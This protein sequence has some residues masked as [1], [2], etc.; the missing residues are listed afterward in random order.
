MTAW[1]SIAIIGLSGRFPDAPNLKAFWRNLEQGVESLS[2]LSDEDLLESGVPADLFR[3]PNYVKKGTLLERADLFDAGFFG[4]NPREAEIIDPQQRIFLECAWEALEDAGYAGEPGANIIG[5]YA[6]STTSSYAFS[7]LLRNPSVLEAAGRYQVMI[8]ND[9]DYLATRVSYKL[10][11]SGPS[12][13]IQTACSTS[14][15]AVQTACNAIL[16]GQCDIALA[17]GVSVGFP[18]KSGYLYS[19]GMIFSPDGH[20]RPFDAEGRGIR[21][22]FGAGIVVLKHLDKALRDRDCIR[23]VIRGAAINN[24]GGVKMGYTTP[25]V[26]GQ[27]RAISEALRLAQVDPDSI[28]YVEAHGTAT[29]V[30]DPIEIAALSRIFRASTDRKQY[31]AIGSVKGNIGHLDAAAGV[32]GLIKTVL[33]LEHRRIPPSLNFHEPNP[34]IDFGNSPFFVNASSAE[35]KSGSEPRR[36]GVSSFGI[37]GTNAHVVLEEAPPRQESKTNWPAQLLV[38]SGKSA[39]TLQAET[40]NMAEYLAANPAVSLADACYTAQVGRRRFPY[41]RILVCSDREDA[42]RILSNSDGRRII[43]KFEEADFRPVVFM[44]SGQG[45]QHAG[46]ARGLYDSQP[47][48]RSTLDDCAAF[49]QDEIHC[50][51][52]K[53]LYSAEARSSLLTETR[54]AQPALFAIEYSLAR[55]WTSWGVQPE[56]MIGHSIGEYVAACLAGVF[57]LEDGLRLVAARGRLMQEMPAGGMMAVRLSSDELRGCI[58]GNLE[59]SLA[60]VNAPGMCTVSGRLEAI[61]EFRASLELR[62]VDCRPLH[63]SHAFHSSMMDDVLPRFHEH[64][65][66]CRLS[67]PKIPF[68]SN[69]T[70][71]WILPEEATD[72]AYWTSHLRQTVRFA[73]GIH[74]L[75]SDPSRVFLEVGPGQALTALARECLRGI[76]QSEVLGTLPHPQDPQTETDHV[77]ATVGRLWLSGV[78]ID[79]DRLHQGETLHRVPLPTYPFESKRYWVLP[80]PDVPNPAKSTSIGKQERR[81]EFKDWFYFPSWRRSVLPTAVVP[82]ESY[83]PWLIFADEKGLGDSFIETLAAR[84][85]SI[86]KVRQGSSF[87]RRSDREYTVDAGRA[88]DYRALLNDIA[89][90][91]LNPRSVLY[92][93]N[94]G[95][96]RS[97]KG[98]AGFHNLLLLA[99]S[100]DGRPFSG[101]IDCIV[102]S[103]GM[104]VVNGN[105]A[106]H[107][108]ASLLLGPCKVIPREYPHIVCRSIDLVAGEDPGSAVQDIIMEPGMPHASRAIAYRSGYRWEQ[109]FEPGP[110]PARTVK[111]LRE[112]GVYLITGG[113]GGIGLTLAAHLAETTR[114]QI[115]LIGR[116]PFPDRSLWPQWIQAHDANDETSR[117]IRELERIES[118]GGQVLPVVADVCDPDSMRQAIRQ[119]RDHFGPING[120]I[121]AAGILDLGLAQ[122]KTKAMADRVLDPKVEGTLILDS[123]LKDEPLDFL[124]LCS[125]VSA[126]YGFAGYIDYAAGNCFLDA[127]A[128]SRFKGGRATVVSVNWD[129]WGEVGMAVK[130]LPGNDTTGQNRQEYDEIAIAPAEGIEAFRR[131]LASGLPQVAVITR[132]L[133]HR[134]EESENDLASSVSFPDSAPDSR[135][136]STADALHVRPN[137]TSAY[138]APETDTQKLMSEIWTESL[139]ISDIGIDD[140]FFALGGH[141]LLATSVLS[142]VRN[143]FRATIPLRAIF[144]APT[145]RLLSEHLDTLLWATSRPTASR[146]E[147]EEREEIEL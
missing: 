80:E 130:K 124:M 94:F 134:L 58:N 93:W 25:S 9:K 76:Q 18:Q 147:S 49:L 2:E 143:N 43:T 28:S 31:C 64:V 102:V 21:A 126:I 82:A 24:D 17:G 38:L 33:A 29:P 62:G 110:L 27:A 8:A 105:E 75:A 125:S 74:E 34:E 48:F 101:R 129:S 68:L 5:V 41:R 141:S 123:M 55:M 98:R 45:S 39:A 60:A 12:L 65:C 20:C 47:V 23:A 144:D 53:I 72:A 16:S 140:N 37:G 118:L 138:A 56:S 10:N 139:G 146:H 85:E 135:P 30:G 83:G 59:V 86:V 35:W 104:H 121:H 99:R 106:V 132:D 26:E 89:A 100:L 15:V 92:L 66:K 133:R 3:N 54:F 116:T 79:W 6:G 19:E 4:Y 114:A 108:E 77:L 120:A 142:R 90:G 52:R 97:G 119:I 131:V 46:M 32:A 51:L 69:L 111:H 117:K 42:T 70:G 84:N 7:N 122:M 50:D 128:M 137:L 109:V 73:D 36:A 61:S 136:R 95:D 112:R 96:S 40:A 44:F 88:E 11:L 107:P 57:T 81:A 113:M 145:I 63:T 71:K 127:F 78:P 13:T 67:T 91:G 1:S 103:S 87:S 115:A 22:G 14:L